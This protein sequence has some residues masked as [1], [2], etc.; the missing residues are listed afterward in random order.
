MSCRQVLYFY[1]NDFKKH[2]HALKIIKLS[3][4]IFYHW[5]TVGSSTLGAFIIMQQMYLKGQTRLVPFPNQKGMKWTPFAGHYLKW[6][7]VK[8]IL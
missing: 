5:V 3:Q 4:N 2:K 6:L 7:R 1:S 8:L